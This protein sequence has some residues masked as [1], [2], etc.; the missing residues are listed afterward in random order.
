[1][2]KILATSEL[3]AKESGI[4]FPFF[5]FRGFFRAHYLAKMAKNYPVDIEAAAKTSSSRASKRA[6]T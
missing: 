4:F 1:M 3:E 6:P 5:D 2:A